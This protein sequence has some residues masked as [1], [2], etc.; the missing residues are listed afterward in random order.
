MQAICKYR[1]A[2]CAIDIPVAFIEV[3]LLLFAYHLDTL[4]R[5]NNEGLT[6][7]ACT[8]GTASVSLSAVVVGSLIVSRK[9]KRCVSLSCG[10]I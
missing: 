3:W 10:E 1:E 8:A 4:E 5:L 2:I 6:E 7:P 9:R